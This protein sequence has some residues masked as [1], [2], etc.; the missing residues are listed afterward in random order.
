MKHKNIVFKTNTFE[1]VEEKIILYKQY[2]SAS[3][4]RFDKLRVN[5]SKSLSEID[6]DRRVNWV[7][8]MII[9]EIRYFIDRLKSILSEEDFNNYKKQNKKIFD[10]LN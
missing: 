10:I 4:S 9:S 7:M 3:Y 8:K 2:I 6:R 5:G 1:P